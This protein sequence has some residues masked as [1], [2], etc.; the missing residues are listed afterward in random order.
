MTALQYVYLA[1]GLSFFLLG[2]YAIMLWR[3]LLRA[4]RRAAQGAG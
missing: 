1:Y 3:G 2:G 4:S